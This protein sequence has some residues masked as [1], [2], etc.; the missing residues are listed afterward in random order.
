MLRPGEGF[1]FF[2]INADNRQTPRA[3]A[4][5]GELTRQVA[6]AW[7]I[8]GRLHIPQNTSSDGLL[9]IWPVRA[10]QPDEDIATLEVEDND[11]GN[12][13]PGLNLRLMVVA[14]RLAVWPVDSDACLLPGSIRF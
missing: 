8:G 9:G 10:W 7:P 1:G 6:V 2:N 12:G 4:S 11:A 5:A 3:D 13:D 14:G